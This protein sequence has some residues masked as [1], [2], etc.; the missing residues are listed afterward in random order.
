MTVHELLPTGHR[1]I[2][3]LEMISI[4]KRFPGVLANNKVNFDVHAGEVHALLGE[5]GAGK[6]TLMKILYGM[7]QP[8]EGQII[9]D[10]EQVKI[11]SPV[12]SIKLGIG[13]IHQHFMLVESLTVAENVALGLPSSRGPLTDLDKVSARILELSEIY[14]LQVDPDAYVWQL[15]VGQQ[16]RVEIIKALYRGAAL[17]ILDEPTA[18]LTPQEVDDFFVTMRQMVTDGHALIFISHKLHEVLDISHRISVLR[19]GHMIGTIPAQGATKGKLAKMMVGREVGLKKERVTINLNKTRLVLK[20][21]CAQSNRGTPA[22]KDVTLEVH[23]GEILG[24]AGVSGNGQKEL[25]EVITG[26]RSISRGQILLEGEDVTGK[27]PKELINKSLS[28]IPEERMRDGMIKE[29]TVAENLILREHS[30]EPYARKGFLNLKAISIHSEKLIKSFNV[31]TPSQETMVKNLSG[32]NIQKLVLARELARKP[33][34]LIAAQPTRGLDIGATEYVHLQ[35]LE[36][37]EEG[38]ATLLISEDLDEILVLSDRIAVIF[39]GKIMAVIDRE[40]ATPE[41]LGLLMAGVQG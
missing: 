38:T 5:N 31:K 15:A 36:Q 8:E 20:D 26:L 32:G 22:L 21:I 2:S 12:D 24:V 39:E 10:G 40:Q 23:T 30:Q 3:H 18:V 35:L 4:T 34:T 1:K 41:K 9:L 28:Y 7:Y 16:Q 27:S 37:R 33:R 19:D 11:E 29:F 13:M 17:L 6:S 14:G 25:A